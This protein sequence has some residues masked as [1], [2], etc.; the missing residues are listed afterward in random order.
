MP[1]PSFSPV[2]DPEEISLPPLPVPVAALASLHELAKGRSGGSQ[3]A[4]YFLFWLVGDQEPS[5][6]V[7]DGA[8]ELRRLDAP[9]RKAAVEV[10]AWWA[11]GLNVKPLEDVLDDL[12]FR[13]SPQETLSK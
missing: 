4:R 7:G 13:F 9:H 2:P 11:E 8:L 1:D 5:G 6:H 12:H 10:L 3:A